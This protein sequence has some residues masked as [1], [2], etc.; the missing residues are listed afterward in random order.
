[1]NS[2]HPLNNV[3]PSVSS[4]IL[5]QNTSKPVS[6]PTPER[7]VIAL[8]EFFTWYYQDPDGMIQGPFTSG[9]M[10]EW[11]DAGYFTM[12]LMVRRACDNHMLPL[13]LSSTYLSSCVHAYVHVC[14]SA[15]IL[16]LRQILLL[17]EYLLRFW[18]SDSKIGTLDQVFVIMS[19]I[20][21]NIFVNCLRVAGTNMSNGYESTCS[22]ILNR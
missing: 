15:C 19:L 6:L 20:G 18:C 1:M 4:T 14:I 21:T 10:K 8:E 17:E 11:F 13:G 12:D 3:I 7:G 16:G 9:E 22:R 2:S 5:Q